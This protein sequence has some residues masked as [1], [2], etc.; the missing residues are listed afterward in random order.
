[1]RFVMAWVRT[2]TRTEVV[3]ASSA[4]SVIISLVAA[5]AAFGGE[6]GQEKIRF[7]PADQA[8]ARAVI[9]RRADL[10]P[11]GGW[12]GGSTK[13][14]HSS[15]ACP[16]F[17]QDL[18]D[19]VLTGSAA[20]VWRRPGREIFSQVDVLRTAR[21]VRL[22]WQRSVKA[23]GALSCLRWTLARGLGSS[24]KV[25]SVEW[26]AF[27]DIAPYTV[28]VRFIYDVKEQG[29]SQ[30]MA[31]EEIEMARGRT[32]IDLAVTAPAAKQSIA[33]AEALR[34]AHT[35]VGRTHA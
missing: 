10:E 18:S 16:G 20:T 24:G 17:H 5:V 8:A 33:S 29:Q 6:G 21:M 34:L 26:I 11:T 13:S 12:R 14:D 23:P 7:N 32:E 27:P 30:R 28:A 31:T 4:L 1:M 25:I 15:L 22:D 19:L 35:L 3:A 2:H 9:L